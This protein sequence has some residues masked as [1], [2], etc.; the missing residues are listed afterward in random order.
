MNLATAEIVKGEVVVVRVTRLRSLRVHAQ[1][2][3]PKVLR[4]LIV[5]ASSS[6]YNSSLILSFKA[7]R[8]SR[9]LPESV[10][11]SV[12]CGRVQALLDGIEREE[13]EAKR[14]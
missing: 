4:C 12:I 13:G 11:S 1:D 10:E 14:Y 8:Q 2:S 7:G 5:N 6:E 3:S 9:S